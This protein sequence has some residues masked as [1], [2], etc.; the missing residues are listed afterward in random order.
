MSPIT[1]E[2]VVERRQSHVRWSVIFAGTAFSIGVWI[3]LQALGMGL[4]L[5]AVDTDNAGS[6][7]GVGI[8]TGIWSLIAP[9]IAL[10]VGGLVV[11]R[12]AGTRERL[13]AAIHAGVMWALAITIGVWAV[14]SIASMM[15]S[16][17]A[18][19]GGA[20]AGATSAVVSGTMQAGSGLDS[21]AAMSALGID[22]NDLLGPVNQRLQREGKPPVSARQ[23]NATVRAVA[24][25]GLHDGRLDRQTLVDELV[26]NT[27]LSRADAEDLA[28]QFGARYEELANRLQTGAQ[29]VGEQAKDVA[30]ETVDKAGKTL[31]FG[32]IMMLL[33][34]C[35]ACGG[36]A[37][38]AARSHRD[39]GQT[40]PVRRDD[41]ITP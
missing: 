4:G 11:G 22:A 5:A 31:L 40:I 30:L 39:R 7:R 1:R 35:A 34:L 13:A 25:R 26:R 33:S 14:L 19:L 9:L 3:L 21:D 2:A 16:G 15:V 37:L 36:A 24:Q 29:R 18:R 8:G 38:A 32:G 23:L 17:V 12:M 28:N 10:F 20:A 27:S 41:V 6:L